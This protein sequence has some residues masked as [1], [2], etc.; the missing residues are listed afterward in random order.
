MSIYSPFYPVT[1][2][3]FRTHHVSSD[4][5]SSSYSVGLTPR[6]LKSIYGIS[7]DKSN[8]EGMKIAIISAFD[9]PDIL[10]DTQTF[11]ST[12][13]LAM[14]EISVYRLSASP[15]RSTRRWLTETALDVQWASVFARGAEIYAVFARDTTVDGMLEAV[16][17]AKGLQP[18]V[19]SMSFGIEESG[20][21]V[22]LN[23]VFSDSGIVFVSSS[24]DV[25]GRVSFPS[26]SPHVLSVGGSVPYYDLNYRRIDERAWENSGGGGSDLF[27]MPD[28]QR[29]FAPLE[30][31]AQSRRAT[32]DVCF[33]ADASVGAAVYVSS[34][35]GWTTAGGTSLACACMSG[36]CACIVKK[37]PSVKSD[38][39]HSY[40]YRLAGETAYAFPQ[41][42]FYDVIFGSSGEFSAMRGWDF[43]TGLGSITGAW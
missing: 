23:N 38:G 10:R 24:G 34:Q 6:Q 31:L 8:A 14:P 25:G 22:S 41:S 19:I 16:N 36:I 3:L 7:D 21:F 11:C 1:R 17:Y 43:C 12:F 28:Y 18:D 39:I 9:S 29:I 2:A 26:S 30:E 40:L 27:E 4:E 37:Q 33:F 35:G 32:P 13:G 20:N 42:S 5:F 15:L